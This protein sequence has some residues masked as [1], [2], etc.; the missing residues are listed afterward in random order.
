LISQLPSAHGPVGEGD[1][2][3]VGVGV[4]ERAGEEAVAEAPD[5]PARSFPE[6]SDEE[7]E[8]H[9]VRAPHTTTATRTTAAADDLLRIMTAM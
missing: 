1:G 4:L 9:D 7:S 6:E 3:D 2:V 8:E 5:P